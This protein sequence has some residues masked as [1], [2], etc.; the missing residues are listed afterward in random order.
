MA[1]L[2]P[3]DEVDDEE[4]RQISASHSPIPLKHAVSRKVRK[5]NA[6]MFMDFA[7]HHNAMIERMIKENEKRVALEAQ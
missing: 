3:P 1:D 6:S 5:S 7:K 4:S 2:L